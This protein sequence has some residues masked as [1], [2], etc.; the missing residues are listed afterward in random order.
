MFGLHYSADHDVNLD[1]KLQT[2]QLKTLGHCLNLEHN[3]NYFTLT[4]C[5]V[6]C[7]TQ[8]LLPPISH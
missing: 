5:L 3:L 7:T 1:I 8:H 2:I 6:E 4:A